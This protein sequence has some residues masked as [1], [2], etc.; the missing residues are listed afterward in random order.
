MNQ[1]E[2]VLIKD[3]KFDNGV[4][5]AVIVPTNFV[6]VNS[7]FQNYV[8]YLKP[9]HTAADEAMINESTKINLQPPENWGS[10][11]C[12]KINSAG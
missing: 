6:S 9:P 1:Y 8:R 7:N 2:I 11:K 5:T 4:K 3:K 12:E 10:Y